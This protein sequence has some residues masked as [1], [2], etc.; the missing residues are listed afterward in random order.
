MFPT[1]ESGGHDKLS[2]RPEVCMSLSYKHTLTY[3]I[4]LSS[5]RYSSWSPECG[6]EAPGG[7]IQACPE[8]EV[9]GKVIYPLTSKAC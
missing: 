7:T 2:P 6:A 3:L 1:A 4:T 5:S 9:G 8:E